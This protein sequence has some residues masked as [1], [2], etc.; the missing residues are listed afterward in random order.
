MYMHAKAITKLTKCIINK[1]Q[2]LNRLEF[3]IAN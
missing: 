2:A 3:E 1:M